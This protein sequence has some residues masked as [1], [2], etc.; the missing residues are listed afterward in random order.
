MYDSSVCRVST[1]YA[2]VQSVLSEGL[3]RR[4]S[5]QSHILFCFNAHEMVT[6]YRQ[7]VT[8]LIAGKTRIVNTHSIFNERS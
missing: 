8:P 1:F 3:S 4:V 7:T 6:L 5:L 2:L